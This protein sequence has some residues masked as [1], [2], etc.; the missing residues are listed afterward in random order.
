VLDVAGRRVA[1]VNALGC[2]VTYSLNAAS[3]Q[4]SVMDGNGHIATTIRDVGGRVVG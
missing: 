1:S 3:E 4:V 2:R